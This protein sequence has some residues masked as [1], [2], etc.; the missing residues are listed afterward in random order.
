MQKKVCSDLRE[1]CECE[2]IKYCPLEV[3]F[4]SGDVRLFEQHKCVEIFKW[5][6]GVR[7]KRE[8]DWSEGY[9]LWVK[10]GYAEK[11]ADVYEKF[12]NDKMHPKELY[13]LVMGRLK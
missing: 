7:T 13:N 2:H 3:L 1:G 9:D 8:I 10:G 6:E 5:D 12:Y 11:F 4:R